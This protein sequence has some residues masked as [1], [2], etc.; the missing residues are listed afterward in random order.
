MTDVVPVGEVAGDVAEALAERERALLALRDTVLEL[1]ES[2]IA[3]STRHLYEKRWAAVQAWCESFHVPSG[4]MSEATLVG[5][6]AHLAQQ[7]PLPAVSTIEGYLAAI[8]WGL[9]RD[10]F[11]YPKGVR[12]E[13]VLKGYARKRGRA[14]ERQATALREKHHPLIRE[15][16]DFSK[17]RDVRDWALILLD[18]YGGFRRSEL[19]GVKVE[20][21]E[22]DG[23]QGIVI[24]IWRSKADQE[25]RSR[26]VPIPFKK[27]RDLCPVRAYHAWL[28]RSGIRT[29]AIFREVRPN[30]AVVGEGITDQVVAD[31]IRDRALAAG[32]PGKWSG[33]SA[34]RGFVT[35]ATA[36]NKRATAIARHG[37]WKPG[38]AQVPRYAEEVEQWNEENP[39]RW[40]DEE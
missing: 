32:L 38:S 37:G 10:G 26:R 15:A 30:G 24:T 9:G 27:D 3:A 12:L 28:R 40:E 5:Y 13:R 19:A 4:P 21:V 31:V 20:D 18:H 39:A 14:P 35:E 17:P 34:R 16:M 29:G 11:D 8:K 7:K 36:K 33:H 6:V 25:G 1:D 2:S 23:D 22:V